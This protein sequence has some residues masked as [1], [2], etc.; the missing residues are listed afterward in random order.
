MG[1]SNIDQAMSHPAVPTDRAL[2][3][4]QRELLEANERLQR[5]NEELARRYEKSREMDELKSRFFASISHEL[6]TPLT[7]ILGPV[8]RRLAAQGVSPEERRELEVVERNARLLLRYATDLLDVAR[9]ESD[10]KPLSYA[11]FDLALLVRLMASQFETVASDRRIRFGVDAPDALTAQADFDKVRRILLNLLSNAFR[12]VPY[13]GVISVWL[14]A[15]AGQA[16]IGVQDN[17]PGVAPEVR[18]AVFEPFRE[19]NDAM[20]RDGAGAGVGLAVVREFAALHR[21]VAAVDEA[22]GGGALFTVSLPLRAPEGTPLKAAP[23]TV[24]PEAD[25]P[26]A[27]VLRGLL[28]PRI[29]AP[30]AEPERPLVLVVEDNVDMNRFIAVV[31]GPHYRVATAFDGKE[32][33]DMALAFQPDLILSD[34]MMPRMSGERMVRALRKHRELAEVPV[35][36]LTGKADDALRVDLLTEGVQDYLNKPFSAEELLARIGAR[37]SARRRQEAALKALRADMEEL[38]KQQVASQTAAAIA[39]ELNQP[40]SAVAS[41]TDAALRLLQAGNPAPEK[42]QRALEG[43]AAQTQRAGQVVRE[44]LQF[45]QGREAATEAIDLREA[46][47]RALAVVESNGLDG[48]DSIVRLP[49]ALP[50]VLANRLQI[51]KVLVNLVCNGVDAMRA[52]GVNPQSI[53]IDVQRTADGSMAQVTVQDRGPGLS[54]EAVRRVFQP[55]YTTKP[56]GIGMGLAISRAL[57]EANGGRLWAEPAAGAGGIFHFTLPW[58]A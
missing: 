3:G 36:M 22:A 8:A 35:I 4:S 2:A 56:T 26:A 38:S 28:S 30:P 46:I 44:L 40:L 20:D 58:V 10:S 43:G 48:F 42:L 47:D 50:S 39:H 31:L 21:G 13:G 16:I 12:V 24:R 53:A 41:Y 1:A 14:C 54:E 19:A 5:A 34:V 6:R 51:E 7:L 18:E 49:S 45:F 27:D 15:R 37:I 57:V 52:A 23:P 17:G 11:E 9:L 55:F 33:L 25:L 29:G 32:G